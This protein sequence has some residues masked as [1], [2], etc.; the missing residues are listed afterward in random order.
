VVKEPGKAAEVQEIPT[1]ADDLRFFQEAVG[2]YIENC[3]FYI[4]ELVKKTTADPFTVY[5]NEEG[6]M[7][8]LKRNLAVPGDI[9]FG[10]VVVTA[11][12]REGATVSMSLENAMYAARVLDS[13][14]CR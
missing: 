12:N 1:G 14:S 5:C 9:I 6:K 2:G 7:L 11:T 4:P 10:T 8:A 13:Y 3:T